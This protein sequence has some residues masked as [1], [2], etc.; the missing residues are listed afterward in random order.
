MQ[1]M[2]TWAKFGRWWGTG[3]PGMLQFIVSQSQTQL[4]D[5]TTK[6]ILFTFQSALSIFNIFLLRNIFSKAR[7]CFC[8]R[9]SN[10]DD[11]NSYNS[12]FTSKKLRLTEFKH[13]FIFICFINYRV[14][15][16]DSFFI[17]NFLLISYLFFYLHQV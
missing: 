11:D 7:D 1:W 14:N 6:N 15:S 13:W 5:S 10:G 2:W 12:C 3:S 16:G 17:Q 9:S 4:G 8:F